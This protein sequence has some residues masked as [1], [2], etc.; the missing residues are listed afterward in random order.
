MGD[1][2]VILRAATFAATAHVGQTRKGL[3]D[4]YINHPLRVAH[5]AAHAELG[6]DA[7][8]AA[9]LH[10]V[11]EDTAHT[12]DD[13]RVAGFTERA[14]GLARL[15][16]KW[17][18]SGDEGADHDKATYYARILQDRDAVALKLLDRTDNLQD[19]VRVAT[20]RRDFAEKYL[21]KT[22]R[23]FPPLLD[24]CDNAYVLR[25]FEEQLNALEA[26]LDRR[27]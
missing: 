2:V 21:K 14:I 23:E 1:M 25:V 4:P 12:W 19:V 6:E 17:W 9:L 10:D 5:H 15:L 26:M 18:E 7:I 8:V 13:L 22:R 16:T 11:V 3:P 20:A 24:R 27:R